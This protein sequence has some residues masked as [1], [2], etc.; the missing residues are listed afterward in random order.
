MSAGQGPMS[1]NMA[2][3]A[4]QPATLAPAQPTVAQRIAELNDRT[5]NLLQRV[6]HLERASN[7]AISILQELRNELGLQ[8][9]DQSIFE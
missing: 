6:S 4:G 2:A 7:G 3:T 9:L 1:G 8:P 5:D